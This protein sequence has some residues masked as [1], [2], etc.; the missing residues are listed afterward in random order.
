MSSFEVY[1]NNL[2]SQCTPPPSRPNFLPGYPTQ[3]T[4]LPIY[5]TPTRPTCLPGYPTPTYPFL[6]YSPTSYTMMTLSPPTS[7]TSSPDT[8]N[9]P[10]HSSYPM[11]APSYSNSQFCSFSSNTSTLET[12]LY[13][14]EPVATSTPAFPL[15]SPHHITPPRTPGKREMSSPPRF[16]FP[17]DFSLP[18][19]TS[20]ETPSL[21]P[22]LQ[23]APASG[24]TVK[25]RRSRTKF[26]PS[27]LSALETEFDLCSYI[28]PERRRELS[29]SLAIKELAIRVWFQN[30]RT[31]MKKKQKN[32]PKQTPA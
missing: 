25:N 2:F 23:S 13:T 3:P 16:F 18:E 22:P 31:L 29:R 5:P 10:E 21:T 12:P 6:S 20:R 14:P 24:K 8:S 9:P 32:L 26:T 15:I 17:P 19:D 11:R 7:Y 4:C 27:Q 30:R 1:L 28:T